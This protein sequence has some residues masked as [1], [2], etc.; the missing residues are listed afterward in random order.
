VKQV[1]I[2]YQDEHLVVVDKP[3]GLQVHP[4]ESP[5]PGT[6]VLKEHLVKILRNQTGRYVYPVHRLDRATSGVVVMAFESSIAGAIQNQFKQGLVKKTYL[7]LTRGWIGPQ[8][9]V[10]S[11]ET[12]ITDFELLHP[13]TVPK[14][15]GRYTEARYAWVLAQP[16]TGKYHQ[17]RRHLK[18]DSH[19]IIG[20]TVYG[21]GKHN[22]LWRSLVPGSGLYLKAYRLEFKHPA[23]G[24]DLKF[25]SRFGRRWLEAFDV[26]GFCPLV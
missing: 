23:T 3:A 12:G 14:P 9:R 19:P 13:F 17:I 5:T 1:R 22:Q 20:D 18:S 25:Q 6:R 16:Q 11:I 4:P 2:L 26:S 7:A 15:V 10:E 21:D 8:F 24:A